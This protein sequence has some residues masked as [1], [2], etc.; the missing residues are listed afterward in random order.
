M[1]SNFQVNLLTFSSPEMTLP[2][3]EPTFSLKI[4]QINEMTSFM[5]NCDMDVFHVLSPIEGKQVKYKQQR[6]N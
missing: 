6:G 3:L 2:E 5:R 1:F 4:L